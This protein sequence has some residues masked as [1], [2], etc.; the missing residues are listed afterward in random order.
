VSLT[1][2]DG[3][4]TNRIVRTDVIEVAT[5]ETRGGSPSGAA[6]GAAI[7]ILAAFLIAPGIAFSPC[8][9]SCTDEKAMLGAT[10]VG[11]PV[12]LG[13]AGYYGF[14]RKKSHVIYRAGQSSS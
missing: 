10:I 9:G 4:L 14:G 3:P 12:G 11:L 5:T 1:L 8:G 6:S 7:G 2:R 13:V